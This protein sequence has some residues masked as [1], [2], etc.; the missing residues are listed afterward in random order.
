VE[1]RIYGIFTNFSK[2]C[3]YFSKDLLGQTPYHQQ[4]VLNYLKMCLSLTQNEPSAPYFLNWNSLDELLLYNSNA[5]ASEL[6]KYLKELKSKE[7]KVG[8]LSASLRKVFTSEKNADLMMERAA[9]RPR[10]N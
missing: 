3:K 4:S 2:Y 10:N 8:S 6:S 1:A 5:K 9:K 7:V